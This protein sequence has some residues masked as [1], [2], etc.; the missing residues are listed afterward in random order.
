M[1]LPK[2]IVN[3]TSTQFEVIENEKITSCNIEDIVV[4]GA[5]LSLTV[6]ENVTF[7]NCIFFASRLENCQFLSCNFI[8]CSFQFTNIIYCDY[9]FST[10]EKCS[11]ETSFA[12]NSLFSR[13]EI[14]FKSLHY[15][16]VVGNKNR[17]LIGGQRNDSREKEEIASKVSA[18]QYEE[19][20]EY[21][22][23]DL[24]A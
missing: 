12:K 7:K 10:F 3:G 1:S 19:T 2:K 13:C 6:F 5:L 22:I 24:A 9:H 16:D 18:F 20:E 11:W 14:D 17:F 15:L 23:S 21:I 4:A 8:G